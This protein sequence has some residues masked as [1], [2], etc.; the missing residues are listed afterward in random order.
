M[1]NI[2]RPITP[3][4]DF[5]QA[6]IHAD[7]SEKEYEIIEYIRYTGIFSQPIITKDL[8]LKSKPPVFSIICEASRKIGIHMPSHFEAVRKWSKIINP[9]GVKWDGDLICSAIQ[10]IDGDL[11]TPENGNSL[12]DFLSVHKELFTGF[13]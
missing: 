10:N 3:V 8:R 11:L 6:I 2:I 7:L 12:Y 1:R 9:N 13:S 5:E 4:K